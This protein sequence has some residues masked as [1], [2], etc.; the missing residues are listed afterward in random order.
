MFGIRLSFIQYFLSSI[1]IAIY[2]NNLMNGSG[3]IKLTHLAQHIISSPNAKA[4]ILDWGVEAAQA[5]RMSLLVNANLIFAVVLLFFNLVCNFFLGELRLIEEHN[6]RERTINFLLFKII[7]IGAIVEPE[8]LELMTWAS[9]FVILG[10]IKMLGSLGRDRFEHVAVAPNITTFAHFRLISLLSL[11]LISCVAWSMTCINTFWIGGGP[12]VVLLL[13]FECMTCII[14]M[15]QTLTKYIVHG[16]DL[17]YYNNEWD[18]RGPLWY[19]IGFVGDVI[20]LSISVG[21]YIHVWSLNGISVN[22]ID[23][24][25]FLNIRVTIG[26]ILKQLKGWS[27]YRKM[28]HQLN[29]TYPTATEDELIQMNE[30]CAICLRHLDEAKRL[31][32]NH[33]FHRGK[34]IK[35]GK[36]GAM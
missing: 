34:Y 36:A 23:A 29:V 26:N 6:L 14:I 3:Y 30:N 2:C 35:S 8:L 32:C 1:A 9:C 17:Y 16:I 19:F 12:N 15:L 20:S 13:L 18:W 33:Y 27:N 5:S 22:L 28:M 31:P 4:N 7:F 21:H 25:L 11:V 10:M 24:I